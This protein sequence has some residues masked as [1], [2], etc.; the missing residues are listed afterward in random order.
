MIFGKGLEKVDLRL[1][2]IFWSQ[3]LLLPCFIREVLVKLYCN[4]G[5]VFN[6]IEI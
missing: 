3:V 5:S 6:E 4:K 2:V 1:E